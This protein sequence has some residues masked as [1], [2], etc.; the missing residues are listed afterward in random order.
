M[1]IAFACPLCSGNLI[2]DVAGAGLTVDCPHCGK[3]ITIPKPDIPDDAWRHHGITPKQTAVLL[4]F[5]VT[6]SRDI[7][8]GAA[9]D[10]ISTLFNQPGNAHLWK[11]AKNKK[12]VEFK[13]TPFYDYLLKHCNMYED[14]FDDK[15][16]GVLLWLNA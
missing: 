2:V 5:N 8:S 16:L 4:F 1:D 7:K 12:M 9:S 10:I 3:P 14:A 15:T 6:F 11:Q 13:G